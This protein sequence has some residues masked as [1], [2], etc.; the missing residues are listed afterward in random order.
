[1]P[2][3]AKETVGV[4]GLAPRSR[5]QQ[6]TVDASTRQTVE[7]GRLVLRERVQQRAAEQIERPS[8]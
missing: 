4:M 5:M 8:K 3:I 7:V 1:M 6:R 2:Q